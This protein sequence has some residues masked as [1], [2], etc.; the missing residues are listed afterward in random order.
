RTI[1]IERSNGA[2]LAPE[3]AHR[4]AEVARQ[5]AETARRAAEQARTE[6]LA[7]V[8]RVR[9][10][11]RARCGQAGEDL[12]ADASMDQLALCG[13]DIR[14]EVRAALAE[15]RAAVARAPGLSAAD[16]ERVLAGIAQAERRQER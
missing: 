9:I 12:P 13:R 11:L 16:R 5:E 3:A 6:A 2:V 8:E 15:A 14:A 7:E 4:M 1:R 10:D